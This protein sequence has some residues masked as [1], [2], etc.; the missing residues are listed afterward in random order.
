M[1]YLQKA[2]NNYFGFM[3][4]TEDAR[5]NVYPVASSEASAIQIGDVVTLS[6]TLATARV[7]AGA[8]FTGS[9][10]GVAAS[11]LAVGAGSTAPTRYG[12]DAATLLKVWDDPYQIFVTCDTTS[13]LVQSTSIGKTVDVLATGAVGDTGVPTGFL[14]SRMAISAVTAS[15][16]AAPFRIIGLHPIEDGFSTDA[17]GAGVAASVRKLLVIPQSHLLGIGEAGHVTT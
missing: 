13:G 15:S 16:G 17:G 14:T 3:P 1:A 8:P 9:I 5:I 10:L 11:A 7:I 4:A 6:T 12:G 2:T